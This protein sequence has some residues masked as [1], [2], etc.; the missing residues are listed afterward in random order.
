MSVAHCRT[1]SQNVWRIP[2]AVADAAN[3][4]V[5]DPASGPVTAPSQKRPHGVPLHGQKRDRSRIQVTAQL[6]K[7]PKIAKN[8]KKLPKAAQSCQK[9]P[10][11][12]KSCRKLPKVA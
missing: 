2:V 3:F 9:L 8:C 11:I 4:V 5:V 10:K 1:K 6:K 12:A 7:L